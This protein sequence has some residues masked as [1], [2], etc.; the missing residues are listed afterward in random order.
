VGTHAVRLIALA[1]V[2]ASRSATTRARA[3]RQPQLAQE[4]QRSRG[5]LA[6]AV[7]Q[8]LAPIAH[9]A[10]IFR[11]DQVAAAAPDGPGPNN[12]LVSPVVVPE[13]RGARGIP[14][15]WCQPWP[16]SPSLAGSAARDQPPRILGQAER[17]VRPGPSAKAEDGGC[18]LALL[19]A[20]PRR[21]VRFAHRSAA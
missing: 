11:Q 14:W 21:S 6:V 5:A 16:G 19:P 2:S 17:P 13:W 9:Q 3:Q 10:A 12:R 4:T 8:A 18:G 20:T 15:R 1:Q 7:A